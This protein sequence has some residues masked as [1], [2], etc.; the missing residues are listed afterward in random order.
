MSKDEFIKVAPLITEDY[1]KDKYPHRG[2]VEYSNGNHI[3]AGMILEEITDQS[4]QDLMRELVFDWLDMTRTIMDEQSLASR[5][6]RAAIATGYRVSA[7]RSQLSP[8]P[9][10]YLS[11]VIETASLGARSTVED[12]AK[13]NRAFLM[14]AEGGADSKFQPQDIADFFRPDCDL[15]DGSAMT[16]GGLFSALN[17]HV[18]SE[19]SLC[20]VIIPARNFL[21]YILGKRPDGSACNAYHKAGSIDG[22]SSSAYLLLKDRAFVIVL[23]NSSG[24][25]DVTGHIARYILQEALQLSPR[26]DI[27]SLAIEEGRICSTRLEEYER[28]DLPLSQWS[29]DVEDLA[30]TYQHVRYLQQLT[31]TRDG[32]V[33]VHGTKKTSSPMKLVRMYPKVVRILPGMAGFSIERWSVWSD[34]VFEVEIKSHG[35]INLL[36]N[37]GLDRYQKIS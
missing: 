1:Y 7:N 4:L 23:G 31:V 32:T 11:D 14:G 19:E 27:I 10:R 3:F 15:R 17:S 13:L 8:L 21:S 36:G 18:T 9:S 29:D 30:G 12:I 16:L 26:I 2:W 24:P 35:R 37:K 25:L 28:D 6:T 22:F 20:R 33:T 5:T 34:L